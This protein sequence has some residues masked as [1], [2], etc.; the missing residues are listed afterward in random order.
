MVLLLKFMAVFPRSVLQMTGVLIGWMNELFN[1]Q[2]A[3]V[4]EVNLRL[5]GQDAALK[6][7]SLIETGKTLMETPAVWLGQ[8]ERIDRWIADVRGDALL[9]EAIADDRGLLMFLPHLG[10]WEMFNVFFSRY[11]AMTALYQPPRQAALA[12]LLAEV[13]SRRGNE[14]VPTDRRGLTRLFRALNHGGSVVI[15]PDQVPASGTYIPF[16]GQQVLT[17]ELGVR[18]LQRTGARA[19]GVFI[20]RNEQGRF[21]VNIEA[22]PSGIY[23]EDVPTAMVAMNALIERG[24]SIAPA[25]YQWE[26]KRFKE[27]PAGEQ[28][29][30]RFNKPPGVH[31]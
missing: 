23:S 9:R 12:R 16:L 2:A 15:L 20:V 4:T 1:T 7:Q 17:D 30:Y 11:G 31:N 13:R 14:M 24:I 6:R 10:N 22:P 27:R 18:L 21:D 25:Q 8:P 29:V 3:Q 28:K 26:Y 19:L 5:C